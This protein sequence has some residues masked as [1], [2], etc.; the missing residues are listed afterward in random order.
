MSIAERAP[1]LSR[2][3]ADLSLP[4][5]VVTGDDDHVIRTRQSIR[6]ARCLSNARLALILNCGHI[7]QEEM[8]EPFLAAVLPFIESRRTAMSRRRA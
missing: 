4:T 1:R 8:P 3:I 5:L 6:V 2:R 7:P